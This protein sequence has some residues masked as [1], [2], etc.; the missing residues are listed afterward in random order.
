MSAKGARS[1]GSAASRRWDRYVGKPFADEGLGP[2]SY[3]CWG[4]VRAVFRNEKGIELPAYGE[5]TAKDLLAMAH[6][7]D[8]V[9]ALDPWQLIATPQ[10][11]DVALMRGPR[12]GRGIVHVGVMVDAR[13]VL[14]IQKSTHSVIVPVSHYSVSGRIAGYR[15]HKS[16]IE[17]A[18][19][20]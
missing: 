18:A 2:D 5:I 3:H 9:E 10:A 19:T 8:A 11:F 12:G 13:H 16:L 4:L 20:A 7:V 15:R 17:E 6:R 1:A 14:H